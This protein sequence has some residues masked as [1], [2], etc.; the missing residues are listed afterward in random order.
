[1][2]KASEVRS[3]LGEDDTQLLWRLAQQVVIQVRSEACEFKV[4]ERTGGDGG[5]RPEKRGNRVD[6]HPQG[7]QVDGA[8]RHL[9][10]Q[11]RRG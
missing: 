10:R 9:P 8:P 3:V 5:A 11:R 7:A 4:S 1:M 2:L 6:L